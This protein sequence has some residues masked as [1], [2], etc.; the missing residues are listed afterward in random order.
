MFGPSLRMI[1]QCIPELLIGNIFDT[2]DPGDLD[3]WHS[4]P[5]I[6]RVLL[7]PRASVWTKFEEGRSRRF[8]RSI[9]RKRKVT[10]G[11]TDKQTKQSNMPSLLQ[12][13][14][15]GY[16]NYEINY[17]SSHIIIFMKL[18]LNLK[19][20]YDAYPQLIKIITHRSG[21]F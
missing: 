3:L 7:L 18:K 8:S 6:N 16:T 15:G 2:F 5:K 21:N 9:D 11:Q 4:D 14:G 1:G 19:Q 10:D 13:G 12:R 17:R 20:I